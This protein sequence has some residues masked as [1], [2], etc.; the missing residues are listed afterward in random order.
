LATISMALLPSI[1][2]R[3][4]AAKSS[5]RSRARAAPLVTSSGLNTLLRFDP[6]CKR[7]HSIR[8][9]VLVPEMPLGLLNPWAI[10]LMM[11]PNHT[12]F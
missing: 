12:E 8:K 11:I 4:S 7:W 2:S 10:F 6:T 5:N 9:R 3:G 1:S